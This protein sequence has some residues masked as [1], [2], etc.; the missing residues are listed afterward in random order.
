MATKTRLSGLR[1][2][3]LDVVRRSGL[4][5][6]DDLIAVTTE[7]GVTAE[8]DPIQLAALLVRKKLLTKFQAMQLLQGRTQGFRLG[9]YK[10][11]EGVRQDRV[12]MVFLAEDTESK[13]T[14]SVKVLP[15]ERVS[16]D[17][18]YRPF[19]KEAREATRVVHANVARV[20]DVG[21]WCGTHYVVT[22]HVPAPTLDKIL[23]EHDPLTGV[24]NRRRIASRIADCAAD[25]GGGVLLM[26]DIDNF[27]DEFTPDMFTNTGR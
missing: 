14:A 16:D 27:K 2:A 4:L 25:P 24:A 12:G 10:I 7:H 17:T 22:E 21:M 15:T 1:S 5:T 9:K 8:T 6:A 19:L 3:F 20:L 26:I 23:A 18:M 11:V 13:H